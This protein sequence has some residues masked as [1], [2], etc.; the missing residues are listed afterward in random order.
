MSSFLSLVGGCHEQRI[1]LQKARTRLPIILWGGRLWHAPVPSVF[2]KWSLE[3]QLHYTGK[4]IWSCRSTG[5]KFE[6]HSGNKV[7]QKLKHVKL[8]QSPLHLSIKKAN[9]KCWFLNFTAK[10]RCVQ[11]NV[12]RER[13]KMHLEPSISSDHWFS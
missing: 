8:N 7:N 9:W 10:N 4:Q 12:W 11:G 5:R 13:K 1:H 3:P 2:C 6:L